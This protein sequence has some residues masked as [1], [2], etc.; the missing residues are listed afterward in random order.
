MPDCIVPMPW[1]GTLAIRVKDGALLSI[2]FL[3]AG[4]GLHA[5]EHPVAC[6]VRD[7]VHG[8]LSCPHQSWPSIVRY[9]QGSMFQQRVWAAIA[10]IPVGQTRS[11][12]ELARQLDSSARAVGRACGD[13][14]WPL[15]VPCHR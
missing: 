10:A 11:Y 13:N 12:G 9:P 1:G 4:T 14:P 8:Y 7:A 5:P 3:D 6:Q 2:D 15:L